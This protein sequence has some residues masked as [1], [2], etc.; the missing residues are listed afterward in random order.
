[1]VDSTNF[2][3]DQKKLVATLFEQSEQALRVAQEEHQRIANVHNYLMAQAD[4][5][6]ITESK[7]VQPK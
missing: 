3:E 4:L 5:K 1:M 7:A 6:L 2:Y